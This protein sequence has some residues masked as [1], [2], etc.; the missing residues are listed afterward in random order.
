[1]LGLPVPFCR[2]DNA[3]LKGPRSYHDRASCVLCRGRPAQLHWVPLMGDSQ[4]S[5]VPAFCGPQR[6]SPG[7]GT[8]SPGPFFLSHGAYL[9][10]AS[11]AL[12]VRVLGPLS[13]RTKAS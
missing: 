11:R 6:G 12:D 5:P 2:L 9:S 8:D 3:Q 7:M 10:M 13:P 1:M 4:L